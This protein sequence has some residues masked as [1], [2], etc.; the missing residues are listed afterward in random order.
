MARGSAMAPKN[1]QS[2]F[3]FWRRLPPVGI[4][5]LVAAIDRGND[6]AQGAD[7]LRRETAARQRRPQ[8]MDHAGLLFRRGEETGL[9][10][11]AFEMLEQSDQLAFGRGLG[12]P[13]A[14]G[15]RFGLPRLP[16]PF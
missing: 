8:V 5:P 12:K 7:F 10:Q 1:S 4:G 15:Q 14:E 16:P 13:A 2:L 3:A 11:H 9:L 6:P